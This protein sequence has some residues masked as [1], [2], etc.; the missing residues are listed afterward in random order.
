MRYRLLAGT[1][2]VLDEGEGSVAMAGGALVLSP[3]TGEVLR[4]P[5]AGIVEVSEPEPYAVRLVLAEGPVL[6]LLRLGAMRTQLL[7]ELA[8]A[9]ATGVAKTLLLDGV[10][11]AEVFPGAVD[12]VEAELRLYDDALVVLPV[13][14]GAE[15]VPYPFIREVTTDPSGY[16]VSVDVAGRAPLGLHRL[17][18]RTTEFVDL[19]RDRCRATSGRTSAFL[20][21]L[22]P[23][24][25]PVALRSVAALLRDGL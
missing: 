5:P 25:G 17:A 24:L 2:E 9:R 8:D 11:E 18:R 6:D 19:L 22:L 10:G 14:G 12:E 4:V 21:A 1:G 20:G 23:G 16:R 13:R 3:A 7:A 15:K